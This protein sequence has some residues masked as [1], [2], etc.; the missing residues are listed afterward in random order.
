MHT[1]S[2]ENEQR[3]W[4]I[5]TDENG[6]EQWNNTYGFDGYYSEGERVCQTEDGGFIVT[7]STW[8]FQEWGDIY[9]V[10]TDSNGNLEWEKIYEFEFASVT[11]SIE[12]ASDDCYVI[13]GFIKN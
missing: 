4:L 2:P 8:I 11:I 13:S 12:E 1:F 6:N 5:K 9:V 10:K 3:M 7:G